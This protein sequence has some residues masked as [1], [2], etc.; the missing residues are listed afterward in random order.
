LKTYQVTHNAPLFYQST[1]QY[2]C[3]DAWVFIGATEDDARARVFELRA[4]AGNR[5]QRRGA[6]TLGLF[7]PRNGLQK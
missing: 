3:Q 4:V 7:P 5:S 1:H 6:S 2:R